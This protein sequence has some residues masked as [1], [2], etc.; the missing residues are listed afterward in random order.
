MLNR[1]FNRYRKGGCLPWLMV[2]ADSR[3]RSED[4]FRSVTK[5]HVKIIIRLFSLSVTKEQEKRV[6]RPSLKCHSGGGD[7]ARRHPDRCLLVLPFSRISKM[8]WWTSSSVC[9]P[10]R[11]RQTPPRTLVKRDVFPRAKKTGFHG[12]GVYSQFMSVPTE[13]QFYQMKPPTI[14]RF[15]TLNA[16]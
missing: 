7:V 11:E 6:I 14:R 10:L 9:P 12:P 16:K 5:E 13:S 1:F 4:R 3:K 15:T 2:R 8:S